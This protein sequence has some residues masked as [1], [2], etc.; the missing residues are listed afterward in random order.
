MERYDLISL[1]K[2]LTPTL[3][4]REVIGIVQAEKHHGELGYPEKS[5]PEELYGR[6]HLTKK[7]IIFQLKE[8]L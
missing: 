6:F 5:I 2:L 3:F 4:L 8:K 7:M 1:V